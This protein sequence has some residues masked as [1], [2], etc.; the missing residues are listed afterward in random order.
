VNYQEAID[1]LFQ[2][3]PMY[4]RIGAAAYKKDLTNIRDLCRALGNPQHKFKSI[5]IGGT[6]GKGSCA[7]MLAA[8]SQSAG[9]KTG[10]YTSPHLK[11]FT[12]RIKV[13][14][15]EMPESDVAE[16]ITKN[17]LLIDKIQPS[18]FEMSVALA[19]YHFANLKVDIAIV[20]V[21]LGGRLDS[22]NI[23]NPEAALITNISLDHTD[24][25]GSTI[26]A[27]AEEKAGIIKEGVP[28][29][30]G[31]WE[32]SSARVFDRISRQKSADIQYADCNYEIN[33]SNSVFKNKNDGSFYHTDP[34]RY[35]PYFQLK[36]IPG[37]LSIIDV[38]RYQGW[39]FP[40]ESV[41]EGIANIT[42]STGFKGRWQVLKNNPL[43][44][45][46]TVHNI[47]GI[48]LIVNEFARMNPEGLHIV[49]GMVRDKDI[50]GML[51]LL[52]QDAK[53]YF[54]EPDIPRALRAKELFKHAQQVG[55]LGQVI[56][57]VMDAVKLAEKSAKGNDMIFIGGSTFVV[58]EIDGL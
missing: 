29:I 50:T 39:D 25:L 8:I 1:F 51:R 34:S 19:F 36:N 7:H 40:P 20:E 41:Q 27:I 22:T 43:I 49:W 21:G 56:P 46:D 11:R 10:L 42:K 38:L 13:N 57:N 45:C 30:I 24:M 28:I 26:K 33:N 5:H 6:N 16:F 23:L 14:G 48:K 17:K 31:E 32:A 44:I 52:P 35:W 18:F 54:C 37:V 47:A 53:Y 4:Q 15:S 2:A 3:L 9:Y 55:L 58:A 12:E